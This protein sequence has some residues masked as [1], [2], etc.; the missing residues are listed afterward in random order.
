MKINSKILLSMLVVIVLMTGG[1]FMTMCYGD[2]N[3]IVYEQYSS[4]DAELNISMDYVAGWKYR[5]SRG[6]YGSSAQVQ[7]IGKVK[8]KFAPSFVVMIELSSKVKFNPLTIQA[9]ADDIIAKK[10]F[11]P[12]AKILSQ[13][14]IKVF[15]FPAIEILLMYS[16]PEELKSI[17]AKFIPYQERIIVFQKDG[18]FY[19]LKYMNPQ[20]E[21]EVF[22][23]A[24]L[25]C[26]RTLT[27][28]E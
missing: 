13:D 16:T 24:F 22:E 8:G 14:E 2:S 21:F 26:I 17:N 19:T 4:E 3:N 18:K 11:F 7:F 28:K 12:E 20:A 6:P 25:H 10:M 23:E 1:V 9:M 15:G 5:E 27:F